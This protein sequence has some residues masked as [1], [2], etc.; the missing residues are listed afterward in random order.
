[1]RSSGIHNKVIPQTPLVAALVMW[2]RNLTPPHHIISVSRPNCGSLVVSSSWME[3]SLSVTF[4]QGGRVGK[5]K[6]SK[7]ADAEDHGRWGPLHKLLKGS[8]LVLLVKCGT[9][10]SA[11]RVSSRLRGRSASNT[12]LLDTFLEAVQSCWSWL[13]RTIA[14]SYTNF[15]EDC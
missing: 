1:M 10:D 12:D 11:V 8:T 13:S 2:W 5:K 4:A 6:F 3:L 9:I 15:C 7:V 14:L